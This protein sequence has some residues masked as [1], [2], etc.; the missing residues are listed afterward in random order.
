[1]TV[2]HLEAGPD[3]AGQ[4]LDNFLIALLKGVPRTRVYRIIRKGEV[5][6]NGSRCKASTRIHC[7]DRIRVPPLRVASA[8]HPGPIP[9]ALERL[10][11]RILHEDEHLMVL[12][13]PGG[14]AVHGGSGLRMGLIEALKR[15]PVAGGFLELAHRLDRDTSGCLVLARNRAALTAL[16]ARFRA[17]GGV[18]KRYL[19]LCAGA[20][21]RPSLTVR[22]PLRRVAAARGGDGR[23]TTGACGKPAVTRLKRLERFER[24]S[25]VRIELGTGRTH[26]ARVHCRHA[27]LPILGDTR[28]GDFEANR[29]FRRHGLERLFLHAARVR[30]THPATGETLSIE[31]PL[32]DDL[33]GV[34]D[35]LSGAA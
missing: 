14:V 21:T 18:E 10:E 16:H 24:A 2:Q 4:R 29:D 19:A 23:V 11:R 25:L 28:Y 33:Q 3:A 17:A 31:A 20:M 13:K 5:R 1:M 32:P 26:Q 7:G 27:G 22:A 9:P 35:S 12:D 15:H 34:L 30:F 8:A 6:I